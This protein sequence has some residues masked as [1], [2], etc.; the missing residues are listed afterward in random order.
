MHNGLLNFLKVNELHN[1]L[2]HWKKTFFCSE[3]SVNYIYLKIATIFGSFISC[4]GHL[5]IRDGKRLLNSTGKKSSLKIR[6]QNMCKK[7]SK[8]GKKEQKSKKLHKKSKKFE[9]PREK[10]KN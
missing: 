5:Y 9:K 3:K 4:F 1:Y 8:S 6:K 7:F 10:N 2:M